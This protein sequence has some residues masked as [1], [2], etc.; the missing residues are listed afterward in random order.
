MFSKYFIGSVFILISLWFFSLP[1]VSYYNFGS[2]ISYESSYLTMVSF[3]FEL[4]GLFLILIKYLIW[5]FE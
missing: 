3:V 5:V 4:L 2:F 1:F